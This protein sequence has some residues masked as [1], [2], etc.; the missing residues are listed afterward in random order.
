MYNVNITDF[1]FGQ[2]EEINHYLSETSIDMA[3]RI[4]D[5]IIDFALERL[6]VFPFSGQRVI[7]GLTFRNIFKHSYRIIY[8]VIENEVDVLSIVHTHQDIDR[9]M[10]D[11]EFLQ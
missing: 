8:E 2:L 6:E 3:K 5:E 11:L 1:A 4:A 7:E 10:G 9:V